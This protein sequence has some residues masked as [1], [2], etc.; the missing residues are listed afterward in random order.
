MSVTAY[1]GADIFDGINRHKDAALLVDGDSFAGILPITDIPADAEIHPL[2]G[3]TI[4]PGFV[5]LQ[6][7]GGG[8]VLFNSAQTV[9]TLRT[10]AQAHAR[11]GTTSLLPTLITDTPEHV[12]AA[13]DAVEQAI[14]T[15]VPGIIG[16]HIE[17]PHLSVARKGA[18][19]PDLIRKMEPADMALLLNAVKRL[20]ILLVTVAPES[21]TPEQITTLTDAGV[22]ISLGHSDAP[23]DVCK[24]AAAHGATCATHLFNAMSQFTGREPGLVGAALDTPTLHAG[25]IAD[26]IHVCAA[27]IRTALAAKQ[28]PAA[29]FLVTDAMST[30]GSDITEFTLDGRTIYRR[31]GRLTLADGTL[32]GADLNMPTA[33]RFMTS[34]VGVSP[35]EAL[36]MAT[37]KPA[38]MLQ[39]MQVGQLVSDGVANFVHLDD[40]LYLTA[41]WQNGAPVSDVISKP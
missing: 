15:H 39:N 37:S 5:D 24:T 12:R 11:C 25:L 6:V 17:G 28:G 22:H 21:V 36:R 34:K 8:G 3:G 33:L 7:N 31:D 30:V 9:E 14:A 41:V 29:V 18:H 38:K 4:A 40:D 13:I 10:I 26:G 20:P 1:T 2:P 32:A 19:N 27:S 35:D 16:L 23:Y